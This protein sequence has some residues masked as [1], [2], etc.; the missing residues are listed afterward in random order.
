M[1][2]K[3]IEEKRWIK[4]IEKYLEKRKSR[5]TGKKARTMRVR[6][7]VAFIRII[8]PSRFPSPENKAL[9]LSLLA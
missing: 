9:F 4:F 5:E 8:W 6:N 3:D 2:L 7:M 1:N